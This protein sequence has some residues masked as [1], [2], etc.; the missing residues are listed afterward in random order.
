MQHTWRAWSW[1]PTIA[2]A[3]SSS[4]VDRTVHVIVGGSRNAKRKRCLAITSCSCTSNSLVGLP[5]AQVHTPW[6]T[7]CLRSSAS[8][9]FL[10]R[11]RRRSRSFGSATWFSIE[12]R[13]ASDR[14]SNDLLSAFRSTA[15]S[16]RTSRALNFVAAAPTRPFRR[17][18]FCCHRLDS[19]GAKNSKALRS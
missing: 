12:R 17:E 14:L 5:S 1:D 10:Y 15:S 6:A 2:E 18:P 13:H 9:A 16:L 19:N 11:A 7:L 4:Q 8:L 3:A